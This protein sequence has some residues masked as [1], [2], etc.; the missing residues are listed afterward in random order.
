MS[1]A[2]LLVAYT[3]IILMASRFSAFA[4][5]SFSETYGLGIR[6]MSMGRAF[7]AIADDYSA[8]FYNP[9]GLGQL[10]KTSIEIDLIQP[11]HTLEVTYLD[12]GQSIEFYDNKGKKFSDPTEGSNG[13]S[14][15]I[16]FPVL[17]A[18]LNINRSLSALI[19]I[20]I[21]IT[22]GLIVGIPE[23]FNHLFTT[24]TT[25]PDM[26]SLTAFGDSIEHLQVTMG[27][28]LEIKEDLL[29]FGWS[30]MMGSKIKGPHPLRV[31]DVW[32]YVDHPEPL[33]L[34]TDAPLYN[35]I[36]SIWGILFTPYDKRVK[37]GA[38]YRESLWSVF[39]DFSPI[40]A[41]TEGQPVENVR[42]KL[43]EGVGYIPEQYSFGLAYSFNRFTISVD[44]KHKRWSDYPYLES[45]YVLYV[46]NEPEIINTNPGYDISDSPEFDNVTDIGLG[47]EYQYKKGLTFTAGYEYCP[48]PVPDQSY[49][50]SNY[51]DMDKNI[52][53]IGVNYQV[54]SWLKVGSLFQY[55]HLD[56][57]K[58]YK[59]GNEMG[60]SWGWDPSNRQRSYKV[61]GDAFVIGLSAE[62]VL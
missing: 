23:K 18:T 20:P 32:P 42:V 60:Y 35:E 17:G 52:F 49:L 24:N 16:L 58:V 54:N 11:I 34:Q 39:L 6:S 25:A 38:S 37:F 7:T 9:A 22:A 40:Y 5:F 51:L 41:H 57:F 43:E 36:A 55:M 13:G 27:L 14:L 56:D 33:I 2:F 53:S 47:I 19:N 29:Y 48:T 30:A 10:T 31:Y 1:K 3:V 21:N 28:G 12:N 15:D 44:M 50:V 61:E 26:P 8:V 62:F 46:I 45:I 4:S 59:T